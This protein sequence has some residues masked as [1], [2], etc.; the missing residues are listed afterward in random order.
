MI[1]LPFD[2]RDD[3]ARSLSKALKHFATAHPI[4]LAI[5]R[6]GVPLGR[7]IADELS[8][9]L[10]VVLVRKLGAPD[11][12]EY[13][14]GAIDEQGGITLTDSFSMLNISPSY[15]QEE[16]RRQLAL[17]RDRRAHYRSGHQPAICRGR[18]VI[19]VDDGLATGATMTAALDAVRAQN[20]AHLVCAVPVAARESLQSVARH[21]DEVVCLAT[22]EPFM[23]VGRFYRNF[24]GVSDEEVIA[25][26][27]RKPGQKIDPAK[28]QSRLV[29]FT[30]GAVTVEGDL[31]A[32]PSPRGLVI[33]V[34]G[35]GS[36]RHSP[37]NRSVAQ[38]L[39]ALG[40]ATLLFD[41]LTPEEDR[42]YENRFDI[43]LLVQRLESAL[44]WARQTP[45]LA[46]L[47]IGLF[48]A[49]TGAAAALCAAAF[50]PD[51]IM[52]VVSRGG[53]PDMAGKTLLEK[54][55]APTLLLVGSKDTEVLE[56]NR[57]AQSQMPGSANLVVIPGATH[58]FE[59]PGALEQVSHAAGAWFSEWLRN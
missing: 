28:P 16:A 23:A 10:D 53:R 4:V 42:H 1:R 57:L 38:S 54:V 37:R 44:D 21:A 19:V 39:N 20:P 22:P 7:V 11:N 34:H 24:A 2:D 14:I 30:S 25:L 47:P 51:V 58:L 33:F 15:L 41:L 9:E 13:A 12:P 18:T 49:S 17:I 31:T 50:R 40:F 32:P 29:R 36:S 56:L 45:A 3:A 27:S 59:E 5:P 52:A 43:A 8:G 55:Q 26:L 35:S 6:G 46:D 48:G